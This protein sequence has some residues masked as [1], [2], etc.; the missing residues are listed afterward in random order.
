MSGEGGAVISS[1]DSLL[2]GKQ[3]IV[4]IG[5]HMNRERLTEML[6]DC[7]LSDEE[8]ALGEPGWVGMSD[9]FAPWTVQSSSEL[10]ATEATAEEQSPGPEKGLLH[11]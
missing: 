7:L 2:N 6:D 8:L 1:E 3:E 11:E 10:S 5:I 4:L 9:P